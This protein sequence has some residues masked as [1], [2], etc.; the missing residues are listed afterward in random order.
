MA[1]D[2]DETMN[3]KQSLKNKKVLLMGL[4]ILGG[5]VA[6]N[7][8]LRKKLKQELEKKFPHVTLF[9]PSL[10]ATGDNALMIALAGYFSRNKKT[11]WKNLQADA[12]IRLSSAQ[13]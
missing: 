2:T 10:R 5:G 11:A 4:G 9:L 1:T 12:N 7:Y 3:T 6:A 13:S 8:E